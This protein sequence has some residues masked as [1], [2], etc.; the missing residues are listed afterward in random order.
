MPVD[1]ERTRF[2]FLPIERRTQ[3]VMAWLRRRSRTG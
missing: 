3:A 1:R 2:V